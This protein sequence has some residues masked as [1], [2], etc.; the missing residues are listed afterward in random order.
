MKGFL[1]IH[2]QLAA[3]CPTL[4]WYD[5][6]YLSRPISRTTFG[7]RLYNVF[8]SHS[9]VAIFVIRKRANKVDFHHH[10]YGHSLVDNTM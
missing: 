7:K 9:K 8:N 5:I 1:K 2:N 3:T 6:Y 4:H 10:D